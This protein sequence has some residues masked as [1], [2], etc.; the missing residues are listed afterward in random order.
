VVGKK[1]FWGIYKI[2]RHLKINRNINNKIEKGFK[3][4]EKLL[5]TQYP[6]EALK[7]CN[8]LISIIPEDEHWKLGRAYFWKQLCYKQTLDLKNGR[9]AGE[10][11]VEQYKIVGDNVQITNVLRDTASLYEHLGKYDLSLELLNK[12]MD[13]IQSEKALQ[14]LALCFVKKG[15]ILST[16][17][18]DDEAEKYLVAA[19]KM[20]EVTDN[21]AH[22]LTIATHLTEYY[23]KVRDFQKAEE[24][25]EKVDKLLDSLKKKTGYLNNMRYSQNELAK[26]FIA[27]SKGKYKEAIMRLRNFMKFG[28]RPNKKDK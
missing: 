8:E 27:Q 15:K 28:I 6:H 11:A 5:D 23:V 24:Y 9:I 2:R 7:V 16:I 20:I 14:S 18:S 21:D 3:E 22:H 25:S 4:I 19:E 1:E 12:A 17:S 10:K 13:S 26:T